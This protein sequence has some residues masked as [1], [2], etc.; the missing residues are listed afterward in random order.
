LAANADVRWTY[1][2]FHKPVW[3]V[4]KHKNPDHNS[5]TLGW[6]AIEGALQGRKYTVFTGHYH[7]Y[8]KTTRKDMDYYILATTGGASTLTGLKDGKFDHFTWVTMNDSEPVIAN[9]LLDGVEDKNVR[10]VPDGGK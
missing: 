8:A 10:V 1:V 2:F 4:T 9:I 6:D 3:T 5:T 7:V